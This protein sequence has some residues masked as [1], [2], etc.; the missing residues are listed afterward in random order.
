[1]RLRSSSIGLAVAA[2]FLVSADGIT[3]HAHALPPCTDMTISNSG[4]GVIRMR[5]G[6]TFSAFPGTGGRTMSWLPG[7][8]VN[9]CPLGGAAF[10]ITNLDR[11]N[12]TVRALR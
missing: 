10:Q 1:M 12:Q 11:N 7:D 8:K 5:N 3:Q 2:L 6:Q 9:V 4:G